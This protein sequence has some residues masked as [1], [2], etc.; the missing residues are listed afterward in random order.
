MATLARRGLMAARQA[1]LIPPPAS[2]LAVRFASKKTGGSSKNRGGKAR[3][4]HFGFKKLDGQYVHA[5]NIIATQRT[6]RWHP[7]A[8]VG[9][10]KNKSLFA[11]EEGTVRYTKEVYVPSPSNTE[12]GD[13]IRQ[14][15][16]GA[17][18]YKTFV[19]VVPAQP[20]GT[21]KLVTML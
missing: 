4:K 11:L 18:L 17:V 15:P 10:G 5:G 6:F 7:G 13:I 16:Q 1:G 19:H 14:L 20:V 9:L 12:A 2:V 8:H 21:F 3:G